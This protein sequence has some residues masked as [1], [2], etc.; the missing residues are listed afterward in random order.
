M[1]CSYIALWHYLG[2][3]NLDVAQCFQSYKVKRGWYSRIIWVLCSLVKPWINRG[4]YSIASQNNVWLSKPA[5]LAHT[6]SPH[7][8]FQSP[9]CYCF[10][11]FC[12][13][14]TNHWSPNKNR[15]E[16]TWEECLGVNRNN[17][18][19]SLKDIQSCK[20]A[21]NSSYVHLHMS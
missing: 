15:G 16:Q 1:F 6:Y 5:P 21:T 4:P 7:W 13:A 18:L 12:Y 19:V 17:T 9:S 3:A 20:E 2:F 14:S 10:F 8:A 11:V